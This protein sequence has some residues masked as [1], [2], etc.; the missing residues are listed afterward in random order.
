MK[1]FTER[2][3]FCRQEKNLTQKQV[4]EFLGMTMRSYQR[5]ELGDRKPDIEKLVVIADFFNVSADYLL[6]RLDDPQRE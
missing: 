4:A 6:G 5:Y 1:M 2:L 3:R